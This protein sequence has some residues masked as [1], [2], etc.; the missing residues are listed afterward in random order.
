[1]GR[2]R[3]SRG[4]S[5]WEA[6]AR[7]PEGAAREEG[8]DEDAVTAFPQ[9]RPGS[10]REDRCVQLPQPRVR[11]AVHNTA[12]FWAAPPA[13]AGSSCGDKDGKPDVA[14]GEG[15]AS[16]ADAAE[17]RRPL[18]SRLLQAPLSREP[19]RLHLV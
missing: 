11:I 17:A 18:T 7:G 12:G 10:C 9:A 2:G 14:S 8:E 4:C 6:G 19:R 15:V 13:Q 1:M 3:Q 16:L 5:S